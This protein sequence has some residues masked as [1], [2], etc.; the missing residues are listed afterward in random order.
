MTQ[1]TGLEEI[2]R[3]FAE[4]EIRALIGLYPQ[5]ADDLDGT[6]FARLF[7]DEG[8]IDIGGQEIKGRA[9]IESWLRSTNEAGPM[10]HFMANP[11]IVLTSP[12]RA[13]GSMDMALLSFRDGQWVVTQTP[14]YNDSFERTAEGWKFAR[15]ILSFRPL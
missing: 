2:W 10:R 6:G 1:V 15:R 12:T 11:R 7:T 9:A 14:R 3:L 5:L 8:V 4:Q 13:H